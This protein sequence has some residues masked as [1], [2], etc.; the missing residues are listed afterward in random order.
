M[1]NWVQNAG[2]GQ[3]I[4]S[5]LPLLGS[6]KVFVVGD[7]GTANR[8]MLVQLFGTDVDGAVRFHATIDAAIGA[9]T[10]DAGDVILVMPG[11]TEALTATSIALD[12]AGVS[13]IGMGQG[14]DRPT[15]TCAA[16]GSTITVTGANCRVEG[17]HFSATV[18]N[19]AAAVT[20]GAAKDFTLKNCT[21]DD[22][23]A[24][25]HFVSIVVTGATDQAAEG[26]R[27]LGNTWN[28][29]AVAP[30][31][32][33]SILAASDRVKINDNKVFMD[34]TNDVGHF[35]TLAAKIVLEFEC[36]RN[37]CIVVG[38]TDATVGVF[39]TG[40]GTTSKGIV[41]DNRCASLDTTTELMFTAGTGLKF[42]DN[43]YT[44][45]AD[46]SGY[47]LPAIDAA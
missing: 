5:S 36:M 39:L 30:N 16:T 42:F 1:S 3:A 46:K 7:S 37:F 35:V 12:V 13:I 8:D 11:H 2:Y 43:T 19:V 10:A 31:A 24:A 25:L 14:L 27:V 23:G 20:L 45:V 21:F 34:A 6:G 47:V 17:L 33:V 40:S 32:F 38:A 22:T 29:L 15:L 18:D 26:L 44:G 9:C 28:G 41:A 4:M